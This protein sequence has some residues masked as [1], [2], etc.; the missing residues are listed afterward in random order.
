M[1]RKEDDKRKVQKKL[2]LNK[3][4]LRDLTPKKDNAAALRGGFGPTYRCTS[5]PA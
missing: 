5:R 3:E 2:S 1:D 4:T